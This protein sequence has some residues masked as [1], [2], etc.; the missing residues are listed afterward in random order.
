MKKE[1]DI[2]LILLFFVGGCKPTDEMIREAIAETEISNVNA[3][4]TKEAIAT[5][6][7]AM[8]PTPKPTSTP[9]VFQI[10]NYKNIQ[11]DVYKA[12]D[13]PIGYDTLSLHYSNEHFTGIENNLAEDWLSLDIDCHDFYSDEP[14]GISIGFSNK[15]S[16]LLK[17]FESAIDLQEFEVLKKEAEEV[18]AQL[19]FEEYTAED[20]TLIKYTAFYMPL[21][22]YGLP[23]VELLSI[24]FH[25]CSF[26]G[27]ISLNCSKDY[28][29]MLS[30][31]E[32]LSVRLSNRL[33][34]VND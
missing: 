19:I 6:T 20:G 16:D 8:T 5:S 9:D 11:E 21:I 32:N 28:E 27:L 1:L 33:G 17:L 25:K 34:C 23:A 4:R 12:G 31:V 18:D 3:T 14:G 10:L 24:A 7:P 13:L 26:T 29:H 15:E 2:F 30:Y 22:D